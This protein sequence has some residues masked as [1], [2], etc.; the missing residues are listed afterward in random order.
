MFQERVERLRARLHEV[1]D[2]IADVLA[3]A[4]N[5]AA[6]DAWVDQGRSPLGRRRHLRLVR[7]GAIPAVKE[8]RRVLVRR[9]DLDAYLARAARPLPRTPRGDDARELETEVSA[10]LDRHRRRQRKRP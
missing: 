2:E 7:E 3:L 4:A 10:V 9:A 8:G 1:A 5:A 6:G